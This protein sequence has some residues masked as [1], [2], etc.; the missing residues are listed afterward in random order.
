MSSTQIE[1]KKEN[2]VEREQAALS[3]KILPYFQR[4]QRSA[5]LIPPVETFAPD[6]WTVIGLLGAWGGDSSRMIDS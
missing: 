3:Y 2:A 1:F 4:I 6:L 5:P